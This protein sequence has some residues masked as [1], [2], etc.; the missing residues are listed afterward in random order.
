MSTQAFLTLSL[1][2]TIAASVLHFTAA[3]AA[4]CWSRVSPAPVAAAYQELNFYPFDE[5][6]QW[7]SEEED[8][9]QESSDI[10]LMNAPVETFLTD[11]D[12]LVETESS[13]RTILERDYKTAD[14]RKLAGQLNKQLPKN[15]KISIRGADGRALRKPELID[16]L[17]PHV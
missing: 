1:E 11:P 6:E 2:A 9:W 8:S 13:K 10:E 5:L 14:L 17:L 12:E 4:Y 7:I 15:Q 3:F 16:V